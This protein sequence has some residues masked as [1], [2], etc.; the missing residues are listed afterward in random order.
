MTSLNNANAHFSEFAFIGLLKTAKCL[1]QELDDFRKSSSGSIEEKVLWQQ[2]EK[3][4]QEIE[5]YQDM[6][7]EKISDLVMMHANHSHALKSEKRCEL[8]G[9]QR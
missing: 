9:R 8:H 6:L 7:P 4:L 1:F 5:T 3:R 2:C